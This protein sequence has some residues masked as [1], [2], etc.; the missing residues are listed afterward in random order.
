MLYYGYFGYDGLAL[1]TTY[2]IQ[3]VK[4]SHSPHAR[5]KDFATHSFIILHKQGG[6]HSLG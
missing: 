3:F 2:N 1:G 5:G 4:Y 6:V